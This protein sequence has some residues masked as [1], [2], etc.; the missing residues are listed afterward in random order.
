MNN[1]NID[2]Q[3]HRGCRGLMPENTIPAFEHA[4]ELGVH[5]LELDVVVNKDQQIVVSHE[6]FF[7][8]EISQ[9]DNGRSISKAEELKYNLYQMTKTEM[10]TIDVGL[11]AHERFPDQ[12]KIATAKP[13]LSEV[14]DMAESKNSDI[15]YNIEI[16][17]RPEWDN[18]YHPDFKVFANLLLQLLHEYDL[19]D[20]A[21]IQ[22]F[23]VETLQY[24]YQL[25]IAYD[26]VYLVE[27]TDGFEKN[28][29]VLGFKPAV[30]SP[31][32]KLVDRKL[33]D[34]C[35]KENI[36][37]IPWTVNEKKD[38]HQMIEFGVDGIISDYPDRVISIINPR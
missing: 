26:L 31:Y 25:D 6:P 24:L 10:D 16:K 20:R 8:H 2:I 36:Q 9:L 35:R 12:R 22:C 4:I 29:S 19:S 13:L 33:V 5:T 34:D 17:R 14:I 21:T 18:Q 28:M 38:I 37:L 11:K 7:S 15:R 27:N 32:F 3:G 23:D 30:Y 1:N